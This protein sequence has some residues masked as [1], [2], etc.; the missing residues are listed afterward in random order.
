MAA[1]SDQVLGDRRVVAQKDASADCYHAP[2]HLAI[3]NDA[4]TNGN[5]IPACACHSNRAAD[6]NQVPY[7]FVLAYGNA[8]ANMDLVSIASV[9]GLR[10]NDEKQQSGCQSAMARDEA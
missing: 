5:H 8:L 4:S 3:H 1:D 10:G 7:I 6:A 9:K 2:P